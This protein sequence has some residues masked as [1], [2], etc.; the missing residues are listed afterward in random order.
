M[1]PSKSEIEQFAYKFPATFLIWLFGLYFALSGIAAQ[2]YE[3]KT[4]KLGIRAKSYL[5]MLSSSTSN[6]QIFLEWL[7]L[8]KIGKI[9]KE[10][11]K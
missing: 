10:F 3:S 9:Q 4:S 8:T 7:V 1:P 6:R 2:R 11:A 5:P